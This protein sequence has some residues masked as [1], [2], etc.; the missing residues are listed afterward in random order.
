MRLA[1]V[2]RELDT[3]MAAIRDPI[4][5]TVRSV[6]RAISAGIRDESPSDVLCVAQALVTRDRGYDR[7]IAYELL[8]AHRPTMRCVAAADL[9]KIGKGMDSWDDVDA[10]ASFVS[11]PAWREG[12]ISDAEIAK[13]A[14]SRDLWWR[15]AAVVSTV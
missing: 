9:R 14:K 12:R 7:F 8:A 10:F 15:R 3:K 5:A 11:G 4:V 6:R 2:V 1:D 13:W